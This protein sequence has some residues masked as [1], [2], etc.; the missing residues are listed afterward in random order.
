ML[1]PTFHFNILHD[2]LHVFNKKSHILVNKLKGKAKEGQ[3][4]LFQDIALCALD[5]ISGSY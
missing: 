3:F 4:N 5:I 1:T 2:F